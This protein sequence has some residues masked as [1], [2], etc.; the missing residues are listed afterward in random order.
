MAPVHQPRFLQC[1]MNFML[2]IAASP[3]S[4]KIEASFDA[5]I[6]RT[7]FFGLDPDPRSLLKNDQ[8]Y[9]PANFARLLE[10]Y[11]ERA[12]PR[13]SAPTAF[14]NA[15]RSGAAARSAAQQGHRLHRAGARRTGIARL[16]AGARI[17]D[18]NPGRA[19]DGQSARIAQRPRQIRGA[20]RVARPQRS[21]VL[22]RRVRQHR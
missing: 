4:A 15:A 9:E 3:K 19:R 17:F 11:D 22:P 6:A 1:T 16:P 7:A 18:A 20:E 5:L 8:Q 10:E 13:D 2:A 14:R 21:A 12:G